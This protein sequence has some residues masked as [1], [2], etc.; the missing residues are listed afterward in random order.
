MR[1]IAGTFVILTSLMLVIRC[2]AAPSV[3]DGLVGCWDFDEGGLVTAMDMSGTGN[4]G[5]MMNTTYAVPPPGTVSTASLF[6]NNTQEGNA[7]SYVT[8]PDSSS[9]EPSSGLTLAAWV[10]SNT[11]EDR[12]RVI[13]GKQCGLSYIDSYALWYQYGTVRFCIYNGITLRT[14]SLTQPPADEWHYIAGTYDGSMMRLYVDG[15]EKY[16]S[17][18][19][20]SIRYATNSVLIGADSDQADHSPDQGWN[21]FIDDVL[22]Y[23]RSLTQAEILQVIP[24][25]PSVLASALFMLAAIIGIMTYTWRRAKQASFSIS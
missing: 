21:G 13:I 5:T 23:N 10:K 14:I 25:F 6:F 19:S 7:Y 18:M 8:I 3:T 17:T 24:E 22:I 4:N 16:N 1:K 2:F 12:S 20:G 15:I 9:L 11:I